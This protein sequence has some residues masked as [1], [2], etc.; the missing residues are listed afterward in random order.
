MKVTFVYPTSENLGIEYLSSVLRQE[1]H[2]SELIFDPC[3]F[4]DTIHY[5]PFLKHLFAFK[6]HM[7]NRIIKSQADLVCFSVVSDFYPWACEIAKEVK[8]RTKVPIVFGG[9][10]PTSVPEQVISNDFVDYVVI[11]EGEG[12]IVELVRSL[13]QKDDD[14]RIKNVWLKRDGQIIRNE[15]RDL[16]QDLDSLPFPDKA[17][18]AKEYTDFKG[19]YTIITS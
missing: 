12:A 16:I 13:E 14:Y 15:P 1:G 7:L 17:L 6:K 11:G 19:Q 9:I 10:H 3:L 2:Q 4:N 5:N 18:Y 8:K